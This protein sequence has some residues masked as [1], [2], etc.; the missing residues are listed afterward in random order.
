MTTDNF[1]L[2]SADKEKLCI[3][4]STRRFFIDTRCRR[5]SDHNENYDLDLTKDEFVEIVEENEEE[6]LA[7]AADVGIDLDALEESFE[8]V[9]IKIN[10]DKDGDDSTISTDINGI[11]E[12]VSETDKN[13]NSAYSMYECRSGCT[14][15]FLLLVLMVVKLNLIIISL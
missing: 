10:S 9:G 3:A 13:K 5:I 12:E 15:T 8:E 4:F 14:I 1:K 11:V 6:L 7:L 2:R